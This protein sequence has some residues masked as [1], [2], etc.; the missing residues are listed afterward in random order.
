MTYYL[1][2]FSNEL[3]TGSKN[4]FTNKLKNVYNLSD[5]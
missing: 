5:P 4:N 3:K 1:I 2:I